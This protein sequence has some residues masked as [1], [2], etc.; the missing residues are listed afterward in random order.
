M[1]RAPEMAALDDRLAQLH[2]H[3]FGSDPAVANAAARGYLASIRGSHSG[4]ADPGVEQ[5]P[6]EL[7]S[8]VGHWSAEISERLSG[9][10]QLGSTAHQGLRGSVESAVR[11]ESAEWAKPDLVDRL[12]TILYHHVLVDDPRMA[13]ESLARVEQA[14]DN[15]T[16]GINARTQ[17]D[18]WSEGSLPY[19]SYGVPA[20]NQQPPA[21]MRDES[22]EHLGPTSSTAELDQRLEQLAYRHVLVDDPYLAQLNLDTTA[23]IMRGWSQDT[24][25]AGLAPVAGVDGDHVAAQRWAFDHGL[26]FTPDMNVPAPDLEPPALDGLAIDI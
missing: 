9:A 1:D 25:A 3:F 7:R 14:I 4:S 10:A 11:R 16:M 6:A 15:W 2:G 8:V 17:G 12:E 24:T 5:G 13:R 23:T 20:R 22:R 19:P 26:S 21:Y 18:E